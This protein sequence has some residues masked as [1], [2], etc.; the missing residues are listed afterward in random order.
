MEC[1]I[2]VDIKKIHI[3]SDSQIAVGQLVLGWECKSHQSAIHE[4]KNII[5]QLEKANIIIEISWTPGHA[6]IKGSE[7]ADR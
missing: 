7:H 4:V 1:Q 6:N 3:F 2:H 5:K